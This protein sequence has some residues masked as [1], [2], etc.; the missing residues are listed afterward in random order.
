MQ[1]AIRMFEPLAS[2][3]RRCIGRDTS[4]PLQMAAAAIPFQLRHSN[5]PGLWTSPRLTQ[6][7]E[8]QGARLIYLSGQT[9]A[10]AQYR[11]RGS[12]VRTQAHAVYDNIE[13][14]LRAAG[15]TWDNV[16]KTTT[17]L[18]DAALIKDFR[19]ARME[20]FRNLKAT[21]ANTLLVVSRLAEP[22]FLIEVDVV[23]AVPAG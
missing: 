17:Y 2:L 21:P 6:M 19:E 18:T 5:P 8:V 11:V 12:D 7:V 1:I 14:A 9:A 13:I 22:E 20:R 23:A 3:L 10:D 15:A 4:R 16:V